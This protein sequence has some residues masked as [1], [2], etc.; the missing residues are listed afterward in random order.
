MDSGAVDSPVTLVLKAPNQKYE[1]QTINCFL[2]WTV[3][4]LKSHISNVYPSKPLSKD[5]RL[6]YSGRL[7]QDHLQLRDVLRKQE[8]Y[9]MMHLVCASHSPPGS[10]MPRSPSTASSS[11]SDSSSSGSAGSASSATTPNQDSQPASPSSPPLPESYDGLRYRGSFPQFNPQGPPGVPQWPD[12][13]QVPLQ[14]GFPANMP[15]HPMYMPMQMLWWQQMY[16]RQY[17]MQ[18][19]AAVAASQP[20]SDP[21]PPSPSSVPHQA[22]QPNEAVQPPLGPNPAPN[23]LPENQPANP[24]IQMNAQG[25]AVLND[26]E[27]NRD[28]LDWLYTVSR[29]GVLLSIV[30]FYSSFS[31][32][33]MVIGAM[34]LVYLHQ[35][36]WFPFRPEQQNLGGGDRPE[37]PQQEAERNQDIQEMERL[38]DEGV[39]DDDSGE[40]GGGGPE[41]QAAAAAGGDAGDAAPAPAL[42]EPGFLTTMWSFISTFFTSLIPEGRPQPAN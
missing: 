13:A 15:P 3:E 18:Y 10:P 2:N 37:A 28:W 25:G 23:P 14:G 38:M 20:P 40:E 31:R 17:Y 22:A 39:E 6:V 29:A 33:V 9:H 5:Q 8:G 41:D 32:F 16:A 35:A 12:G 24:N 36:G 26:D 21:P 34:L 11:A 42:P 1:D 27:L 4:R 30:Y 19:Q 7:L